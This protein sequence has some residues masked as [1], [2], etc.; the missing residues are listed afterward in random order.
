[1]KKLSRARAEFIIFPE[2]SEGKRGECHGKQKREEI[3]V[4]ILRSFGFGRIF[5]V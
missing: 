5:M 2:S 4:S 1:M 3:S